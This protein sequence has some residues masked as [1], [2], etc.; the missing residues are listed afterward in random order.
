MS[1]YESAWSEPMTPGDRPLR[2]PHLALWAGAALASSLGAWFVACGGTTGR[3]DLPATATQPDAT[4]GDAATDSLASDAGPGDDVFDLDAGIQYAND[5]RLMGFGDAGTAITNDAG[6]GT[7]WPVCA[8]DTLVRTDGGKVLKVTEVSDDSGSCPT[9]LWT[10]T[11]VGGVGQKLCGTHPCQTCD[12]CMR[13]SQCGSYPTSGFT[14]SGHNSVFPPCSDE[15]EAGTASQGP[16][17]G[18]PLFDLCAALF[19]CVSQSSCTGGG[20]SDPNAAV[21]NCYCGTNVGAACYVDGGANGFCKDAIQAAVQAGPSTTAATIV[22]NLTDPSDPMSLPASHAG[23]E[24]MALY[25]CAVTDCP[26]CFSSDG[27]TD[28]G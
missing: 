28:G 12:E 24:V 11:F 14:T 5:A 13:F 1:C 17:A 22:A 4:A 2:R 7:G 25:A 16:G 15:R 6:R 8:P 18:M 26:M 3:E 19:D 9:Y 27:G 20:P 21:S 10:P 23:T